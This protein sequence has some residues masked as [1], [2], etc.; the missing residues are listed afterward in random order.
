[1]A[2]PLV[3]A[4]VVTFNHEQTIGSCIQSLLSQEGF[5]LGEN[6]ELWVTDNASSDDTVLEARRY[7]PRIRLEE[8][9]ENSG[10]TGAH[11][12]GAVRALERGA[13]YLFIV[14]PDLRLEPGAL[15]VL[16]RALESDPRAGAACPKLFRADE[17][18]QPV[19]PRRFDSTGMFIT[20][21]IRHFDRGSNELDT[22]QF[23]LPQYVFGASGAAALLRAD[24][25]RDVSLPSLDGGEQSTLFDPLF[26]AYRED[27]DLF[28]RA[29]WLGWKCRYEPSA[30]GYHRRKV[31]PENRSGLEPELNA[32][33]VRNRFLMQI[34][35]GWRSMRLLPALWR[36]A[37]VKFGVY[38]RERSS[39]A[40]LQS[41]E[42]LRPVSKRH[43]YWISKKRRIQ[44][45]EME[46]W[47][48][49]APHFEPALAA[50]TEAA[51]RISSVT[52]VIVNYQS[53]E[54]LL[55]CL[56][57]LRFTGAKQNISVLVRVVDNNSSDDSL[58]RARDEAARQPNISIDRADRNLGFAGAINRAVRDSRADA[59]LVL[60]PDIRM[61]EAALDELIHALE[62]H[63]EIA[64]AAPVLIDAECKPQ[65]D[66]IAREFPTVG[67]TIVE[68]F[69]VHKLWPANP[70]TARYKKT[71]DPF[72]KR[73]ALRL[74]NAEGAPADDLG[75]PFLVSQPAAAC[76]LIRDEAYQAI[77]GFDE[78]FYPAW[79]EDVDF[80]LRL[81]QNNLRCA[82]IS[83]ARVEHEGG[84]SYRALGESRFAGIWY[85]NLARYW[86]KHGTKSARLLLRAVLPIALLL[87]SSAAVIKVPL[88]VARGRDTSDLVESGRT[89]FRL[90]IDSL[91]QAA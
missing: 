49:F 1:M 86:Q 73:Y 9:R 69:G 50:D 61:N 85:P 79:F 47:F 68:L 27:A 21:A 44:P 23:D 88:Y 52:V 84:Y 31:L 28:W 39:V 63:R 75:E 34:N 7:L 19:V 80:C 40:A 25:I 81:S 56:E 37:L 82:L 10:F 89:H 14:N 76:L 8:R 62:T 54:R 20:P 42:A 91:R 6:Y 35:N 17:M 59:Y 24:F 22:G 51:S 66:Y 41:S 2:E 38:F 48:S 74:P 83:T 43:R 57:S 3:V 78:R 46:R 71:A 29:Q 18:L 5:R 60:N 87:R 12:R 65:W 16:C 55:R 45:A 32:Y 53:G 13:K 70:W 30:I 15:K 33:S 58:D 11:N 4:H 77:G 36:N 67:S 64:A 72:L 90:A 26:F